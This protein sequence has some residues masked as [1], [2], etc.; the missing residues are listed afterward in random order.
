MGVFSSAHLSQIIPESSGGLG[1]FQAALA[2]MPVWL[3]V[4]RLDETLS[5]I[6]NL[7]DFAGRSL[8]HKLTSRR[9]AP[10]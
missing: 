6:S 10:Y 5:A 8:V 2:F 3:S 7:V 9:N 1:A 4:V